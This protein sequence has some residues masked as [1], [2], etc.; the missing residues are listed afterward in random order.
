M[1]GVNMDKKLQE[2]NKH[3]YGCFTVEKEVN[4]LYVATTKKF[5][6]TQLSVITT[7]L[8]YNHQKNAAVIREILIPLIRTHVSSC[9]LSQEF[10]EGIEE[11]RELRNMLSMKDDMEYEETSDLLKDLATIED[12][13]DGLYAYLIESEFIENYSYAFSEISGLTSENLQY[14]LQALKQDNIKHREILIEGTF[15]YQKNH[16]SNIDTTPIVRYKNPNA[17]VR[18]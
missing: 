10:T 7:A 2:V 3:L 6:Q 8:A 16:Q 13:L 18:L 9:K 5:P 17:W 4:L 1:L 11:I 15:F 12:Y 14:I